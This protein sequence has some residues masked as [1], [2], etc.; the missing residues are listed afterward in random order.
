MTTTSLPIPRKHH[1]FITL[2]IFLITFAAGIFY[3]KPQWDEV[4]ASSFAVQQKQQQKDQLT[5]QLQQLKD[6]QQSLNAG[7]EVEKSTTLN[8][9]PERFEQDKLM[10]DIYAIAQK[11]QVV[12]NGINFN[13]PNNESD[14]IKKAG[15]N[16]NLTGSDD[17]LVNFL[18]NIESNQR[19]IIVKII[20]VQSGKT[21]S[22]AIRLNFNLNMET[23]Y[24]N[25]I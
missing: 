4:T 9:I 7:S 5:Q 16:I 19:K 17:G 12:I 24:Q 8:A 18:K 10:A 14:R 1:S 3:V 25:N 13:L 21:E 15:I 20:S 11:N 6:L 22:G 2:F 23:Y